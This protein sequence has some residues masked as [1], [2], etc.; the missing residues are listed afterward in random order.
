MSKREIKPFK[1]ENLMKSNF[2]IGNKYKASI[3]ENKITYIA[4]LKIQ[5]KE[6]EEKADGIYVS[7]TASELKEQLQSN[8][9][10][11][12]GTLKT[13]ANEMTGNNFGI[14]DDEHERFEFITLINKASYSDGEFEVR[15]AND[16]KQN[17]VN[18]KKNF[19]NLPAEV[20]LNFKNKYSFPL[21]QFLKSQCYYPASYRGARDNVFAVS[22]GVSELKLDMGVVNSQID[23]VK[24]VLANGKGTRADYDKAVAVSPEKMFEKWGD[25]DRRAL[26]PAIKEINEKSDIYVEYKKKTA[27]KG[28]KIRDVEFTV[29]LNGAEKTN[30]ENDPVGLE[31]GEI[32]SK[33][34]DEDKFVKT[35]EIAEVLKQVDLLLN[36]A[37]IVSIAEE[38]IYNVD[39]VKKACLVYK[40]AKNVDNAVGFIISAIKKGYEPSKSS[41]KTTNKFNN[42]EE[43]EYDFDDLEKVLLK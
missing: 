23:V 16:L 4:M 35:L 15:F 1:Q 10:S 5:N 33:L 24:K 8:S 28:G 9:G 13:V 30:Y 7:M 29:W 32:V 43:R 21:Y 25:F 22:I 6:Y 17:L 39:T 38:A 40:N 3:Y 19:T 18:I 27:G 34:S 41:N 14:A 42:F 11:F 12:Y 37:E 20:V 2:F 36:Y 26:K 31:E